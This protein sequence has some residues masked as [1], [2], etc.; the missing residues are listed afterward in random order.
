MITKKTPKDVFLF[1]VLRNFSNA[2]PV[3]FC[4]SL[5]IHPKRCHFSTKY[6]PNERTGMS[7]SELIHQPKRPKRYDLIRCIL[8]LVAHDK[9]VRH[10]RY[11]FL[12]FLLASNLK[13]VFSHAE[14][15]M[16]SPIAPSCTAIMMRL[17]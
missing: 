17:S 1:G 3:L 6:I 8:Y 11:L 9:S 14:I 2:F 7:K 5:R 12:A 13:R 15:T 4:H 10:F 16:S